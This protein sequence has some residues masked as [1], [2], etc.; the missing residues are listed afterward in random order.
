[1]PNREPLRVG[2][3]AGVLIEKDGKYLL[4]Q[5]KK[6]VAYGLWNLPAGK[7][8]GNDTFADTAVRE[9]KEETGLDVEIIRKIGVFHN[10]G[11]GA[12]KHAFSAKVIGDTLHV[13]KDEV[14]DV[15][16]FTY[17]EIMKMKDKLRDPWVLD[18]ISALKNM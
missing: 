3:A 13:K 11:E 2:V 15:K 6:K 12:V 4:I 7:V 1:M 16:W 8:E 5:E 14:L 10:D 18:S 17:D 9:A